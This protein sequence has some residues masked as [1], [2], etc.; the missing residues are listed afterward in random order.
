MTTEEMI[1]FS[2]IANEK[3]NYL[4]LTEQLVESDEYNDMSLWESIEKLKYETRHPCGDMP[5]FDKD[6]LKIYGGV[7]KYLT[8]DSISYMLE[9]I[10]TRNKLFEESFRESLEE[11]NSEDD[12]EE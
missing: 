6:I 8:P 7:L 10:K 11:E 3:L 2:K 4:V 9:D 5:Y 12:W 1:T